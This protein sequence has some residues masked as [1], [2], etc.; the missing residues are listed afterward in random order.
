MKNAVSAP[1]RRRRGAYIPRRTSRIAR[2]ADDSRD[3]LGEDEAMRITDRHA[4]RRTLLVLAAAG[5]LVVSAFTVATTETGGADAA[6]PEGTVRGF[7]IA[8]VVDRGGVGACRYLTGHAV[9]ELDAVE[10]RDTSCEAALS[11]ARLRLGDEWLNQESSVKRLSYSVEQRGARAWVT[12][13]TDG[14]ART[15][16]LRKAGP[17]E[18]AEF[19]PPPTPWRIDSG[20]DA[21]VSRSPRS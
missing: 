11:S 20:V 13:S 12:V 19:L 10:P 3:A 9:R 6:S 7:L 1:R 15:F 5:A 21:L 17:R 16:G 18:R 2:V 8:A 14:A 4:M